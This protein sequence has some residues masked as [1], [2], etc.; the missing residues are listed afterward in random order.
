MKK[1]INYKTSRI[2]RGFEQL[3]LNWLVSYGCAK[4]SKRVVH[5]AL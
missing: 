4:F 3:L 5:V 2:F 1:N